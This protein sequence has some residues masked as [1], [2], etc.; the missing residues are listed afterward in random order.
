MYDAYR[1][2]VGVVMSPAHE[3]Y[4]YVYMHTSIRGV[5]TPDAATSSAHE[6]H[7]YDVCM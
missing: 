7:E 6:A 3:A 5:P 1:V 4:A 2:P